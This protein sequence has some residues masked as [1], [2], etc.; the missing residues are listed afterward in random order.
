MKIVVL[1]GY[2]LNPGD[3][4]WGDLEKIGSL[5]VH[6]RTAYDLSGQRTIIERIGDAEIVFTNKTPV[7]RE[8]MEKAQNL[9]YIGVLAT[10]FNVVDV[11]AAKEKGITVTNIPTYGTAAV[12]QLTFALLLELCHHVWHHSEEVKKGKW[13]NNQDFCFWDYPLI[14][15]SG[16]TMG[17]IG[18]GKIGQAVGQIAQ[19][20]G[21]KVLAFDAYQN[22]SLECATLKYVDLDGLLSQ[23]DVISL[24]CPLFDSTKGIINKDTIAKMKDGAM[25]LNTSRGPLIVEEDLAEAL[26][27]GKL[28]GAAVDVASQEPIKADNPLLKAKNIIITPHI[29]WAP[30]E[31]RKRLMDIAIDNLKKYLVN[32]PINVVNA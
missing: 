13:T 29:A 1:D 23:S 9:K 28:G 26:N 4:S 3:L 30:I 18:F 2:T 6:D 14:E 25:L 7:T 27:S 21:M 8:I 32:E 24:H 16:K 17:I 20:F 11:V 22:K 10:G 19:A 12:A 31:S 15:L 5:T